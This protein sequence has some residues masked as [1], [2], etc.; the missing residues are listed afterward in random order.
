MPTFLDDIFSPSAGLAD[1]HGGVDNV[2]GSR[3]RVAPFKPVNLEDEQ[4]ISLETNLKNLGSITDLINK[5][6]PGFSDAISGGI[7]SSQNLISAGSDVINAGKPLLEGEIPDDVFAQL[8]R[9]DAF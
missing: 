4:R 3:P 5:I 6:I 1:L 2:Y 7:S 9:D 8:Q